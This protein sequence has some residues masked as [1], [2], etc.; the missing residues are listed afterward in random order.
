MRELTADNL[1]KK[2][3]PYSMIEF[4]KA[5]INNSNKIQQMIIHRDVYSNLYKIIS[6]K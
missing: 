5:T 3:R 2:L 1:N 6:K 4:S